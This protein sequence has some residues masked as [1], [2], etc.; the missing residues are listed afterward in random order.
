MQ[1]LTLLMLEMEYS[2]FGVNTMHGEALA[3]T[4]ARMSTGTVLSELDRQ[5]LRLLHCE[6]DLLLLNKLQDMILNVTTSFIIFNTIHHVLI[7]FSATIVL[8][9]IQVIGII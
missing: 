7:L 2:S 3:H 4:V 5:H 1:G 8:P 9:R 6:F